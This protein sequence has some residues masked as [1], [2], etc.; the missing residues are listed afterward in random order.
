MLNVCVPVHVPAAL[1]DAVRLNVV[2]ML[3]CKTGQRSGSNG[4]NTAESLSSL[5]VPVCSMS[6]YDERKHL[7]KYLIGQQAFH[8]TKCRVMLVPVLC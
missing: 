8:K 6:A 2:S 7:L 1:Q 3:H 5:F 4:P